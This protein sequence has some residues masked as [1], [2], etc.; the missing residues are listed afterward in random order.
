MGLSSLAAR[1]ARQ[2]RPVRWLSVGCLT[3]KCG[4]SS[5][6]AEKRTR[7]SSVKYL[8][9]VHLQLFQ[10]QPSTAA[11]GSAADMLDAPSRWHPG[12]PLAVQHGVQQGRSGRTVG[13][14]RPLSASVQWPSRV[15]TP[16]RAARPHTAKARIEA[17]H[18]S[19]RA[20]ELLARPLLSSASPGS[21]KRKKILRLSKS[22]G[23][24]LEGPPSSL[25][26]PSPLP[27]RPSTAHHHSKKT[28]QQLLQRGGNHAPPLRNM[29]GI[30]TCHVAPVT[31][32]AVSVLLR[33]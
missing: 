28:L 4:A 30:D 27:L 11:S 16:A 5:D 26:P 9:A 24:A 23:G 14:S 8:S 25:R 31:A 17:R 2:G 13:K 19:I 32:A 6:P 15:M 3:S 20:E 18:H 22:A 29:T 33:C 1:R 7:S 12:V 21:N 10:L